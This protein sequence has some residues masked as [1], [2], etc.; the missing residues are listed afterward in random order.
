MKATQNFWIY[1]FLLL[2]GEVILC[3]YFPFS[4]YVVL[5][6]LPAMMLCI[7]LTVGTAG[8]MLIAFGSGLAVDWMS[9]GLIGINA[10]AAVPVA[11]L[12]VS[13]RKRG[14]AFVH[15]DG[16][17]VIKAVEGFFPDLR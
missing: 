5:S 15:R 11:K 16:S 17:H 13:D 3:N 1:Y 4:T 7:P 9:E 6:M 2:I 8:C 12:A 14:V 10:A